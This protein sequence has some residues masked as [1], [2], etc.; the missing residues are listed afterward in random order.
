MET[1]I[2]SNVD[3]GR[4]SRTKVKTRFYHLFLGY[5]FKVNEDRMVDE[6]FEVPKCKCRPGIEFSTFLEIISR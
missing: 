5:E 4:F 6:N 2:I 1:S 3:M